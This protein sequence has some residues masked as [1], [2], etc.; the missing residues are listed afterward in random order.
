MHLIIPNDVISICDN[1]TAYH[2][3]GDFHMM[4]N[5][6]IFADELSTTKIKNTKIVIELITP[7][8]HMGAFFPRNLARKE[9]HKISSEV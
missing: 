7:V 2:I 5:F 9:K 8:V 3:V 1:H 4:P 6:V